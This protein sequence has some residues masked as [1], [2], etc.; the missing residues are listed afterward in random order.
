ML[1]VIFD[2]SELTVVN[3]DEKSIRV[4]KF[5]IIINEKKVKIHS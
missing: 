4:V 2:T 5:F 3:F 1:R